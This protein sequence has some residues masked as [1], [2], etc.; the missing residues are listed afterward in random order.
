MC[1]KESVVAYVLERKSSKVGYALERLYQIIFSLINFK[2]DAARSSMLKPF[3]VF[4]EPA[5]R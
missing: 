1:I 4:N 3:A 5:D 2:I